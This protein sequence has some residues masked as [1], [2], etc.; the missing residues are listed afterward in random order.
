MYFGCHCISRPYHRAWHIGAYSVNFCWMNESQQMCNFSTN[1]TSFLGHKA[2]PACIILCILSKCV[3]SLILPTSLWGHL[4]SV[5]DRERD[6]LIHSFIQQAPAMCQALCWALGIQN[7]IRH[8]PC[9]QGMLGL[10]EEMDKK[11]AVSVQLVSAVRDVCTDP[12][13]PSRGNSQPQSCNY[14]NQSLPNCKLLFSPC[15][16]CSALL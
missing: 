10:M 2:A 1:N 9:P 14:L 11:A 12:G 4:I 13:E 8:G 16:L 3:S 5:L 6:F 15:I 7:W